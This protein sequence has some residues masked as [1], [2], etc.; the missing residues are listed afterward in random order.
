MT[1]LETGA[2]RL[3]GEST[4]RLLKD[5]S[6]DFEAPGEGGES[7]RKP[8]SVRQAWLREVERTQLAGWFQPFVQG[9]AQVL[10]N[11][12]ALPRSPSPHLSV[13]AARTHSGLPAAYR[14]PLHAIAGVQEHLVNAGQTAARIRKHTQGLGGSEAIARATVDS[15]PAETASGLPVAYRPPRHGLAGAQEIPVNAGQPDAGIRTHTQGLGGKEAIAGATVDS[16]PAETVFRLRSAYQLSLQPSSSVQEPQ[17]NADQPNAA[18]GRNTWGLDGNETLSS[19]LANSAYADREMPPSEVGADFHSDSGTDVSRASLAPVASEPPRNPEPF[20]PAQAPSPRLASAFDVG[21]A[22]AS[23]TVHMPGNSSPQVLAPSIAPLAIPV[24]PIESP[25]SSVAVPTGLTPRGDGGRIA[26]APARSDVGAFH[27]SL[28]EIS[29]TASRG[30][31]RLLAA[32]KHQSPGPRVYAQWSATGVELW[33]GMD[34]TAAQVGFQAAALMASL[35]RSL[36]EQG[37]RLV[38]VVCNGQVVF[39]SERQSLSSAAAPSGFA[40]LAAAVPF[41]GA[42]PSGLYFSIFQK[43]NV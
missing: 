11:A 35:E 20:H 30:Y 34:G 38:R 10:T 25:P 12:H 39:D 40:D 22:N 27:K 23:Q 18:V 41:A 19:A 36:R 17:A 3:P 32:E 7:S 24:D 1:V 14:P 6:T 2:T 13:A 4:M 42:L 28:G 9:E 16:D 5:R 31:V 43:G 15:H 8:A 33:L 26:A 21:V 29:S 37:Q